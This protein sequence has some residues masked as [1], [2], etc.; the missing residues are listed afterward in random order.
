MEFFGE[1]KGEGEGRICLFVGLTG[2]FGVW[3]L[4]WI[5]ED[6]RVLVHR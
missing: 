1:G 5:G 4:D 2:F 3:V 6:G